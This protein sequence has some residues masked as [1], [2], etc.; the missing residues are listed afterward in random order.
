VVKA[1]G[2]DDP[3]WLEHSP[4]PP[5]ASSKTKRRCLLPVLLILAVLLAL[6]LI[7]GGWW[8]FHYLSGSGEIHRL[9]HSSAA[10]AYVKR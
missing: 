7:V 4:E 1:G 8:L 5:M 6:A 10:T 2:I 3:V 9:V